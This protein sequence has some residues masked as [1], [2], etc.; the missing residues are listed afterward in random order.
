VVV[1]LVLILSLQSDPSAQVLPLDEE[2]EERAR[3]RLITARL[4][5]LPT[6]GAEP[7]ACLEFDERDLKVT[8]RGKRVGVESIELDRRRGRTLHALLIDTSGSMANSLDYVRFAAREYIDRLD[9]E[10]DRA[11]IVTFD[12][13][14]LLHQGVTGEREMLA[15][16][17]DRVRPGRSTALNDGLH[18]VAQEMSAHRERPVIVLLS[19]GFDTSSL[20]Q[21]EDVRDL[22]DRRPDLTV[23]TIGFN[24][25]PLVS[26]GPPGV[27]SIRRYLHRLAHSTNGKF[28]D[29]PTGSRLDDVYRR[30][31]ETLNTEAILRVVDPDPADDPGKLKVSATKKGCMIQL[32]KTRSPTEDPLARPIERPWADPPFTIDLPPDPRYL[33]TATNRAYHTADPECAPTDDPPHGRNDIELEALWH[34]DVETG[35]IRGCTLDVT[36]DVGPLFDLQAMAIPNPWMVWNAFLKTKTRRFEML[37]PDLHALPRRPDQVARQLADLAI[38]VADQEIERDSR[39]KPY[40]R[41]ARPYHDLP[42]VVHGRTFFDLRERLARG[43]FSY[44]DYRRWVLDKLAEETEEDMQDLRERFRRRAPSASDEAIELAL[45]QSEEGRRIRDRAENPSPLDLTRHLAAWLGDV[46]ALELFERWETERIDGLLADDPPGSDVEVFAE[47]WSALRSLLFAASYARELT[48][49]TPAYDPGLDRIG[50]YRVVLPRPAWYQARIRN[51]RNHPGWTDLPFDL[52]PERPMAHVAFDWLLIENPDVADHLRSQGYR[53]TGLDYSSFAKPR[54]QSPEKAFRQTRVAV[55]L[56]AS[57]GRIRVE[58]DLERQDLDVAQ[59]RM[60]GLRLAVDGDPV[61]ETLASAAQDREQ[62]GVLA[63]AG[64]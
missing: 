35:A 3:A 40:R 1:S 32:F 37:V 42:T 59:T 49:L 6:W 25:P 39:K 61:M 9:P 12:D 28:F 60:V 16:A 24:L 46:P 29:V 18:Y 4:R 47:R 17:V 27:T 64:R 41:H 43:L 48:L 44:P 51:Y 50:F 63:D 56:A 7:G 57:Q 2:I 52:V 8:L 21:R 36:M 58:F 15:A 33:R 54:K 30:I 38:E 20:H 45:A 19:D 55:D 14:V 53:V 22:L 62:L 31:S 34:A 23:F 10:Y 5:I 13:S 26:G 11:L